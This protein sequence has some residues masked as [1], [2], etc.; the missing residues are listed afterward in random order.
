V[1]EDKHALSAQHHAR[2]KRAASMCAALLMSMLR[3]AGQAS[4]QRAA[5]LCA[6]VAT[7]KSGADNEPA[8]ALARHSMLS[9]R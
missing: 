2:H 3:V 9:R 7:A 8:N 1:I 4:A 6:P 5:P